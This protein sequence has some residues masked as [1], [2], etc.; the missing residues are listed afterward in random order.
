M[1]VQCAATAQPEEVVIA[2]S[3]DGRLLEGETS[4]IL[5]ILW[6]LQDS[7]AY[8]PGP[9]LRHQRPAGFQG[10]LLRHQLHGNW[11]SRPDTLCSL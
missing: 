11:T 7:A 10:L 9:S 6:M 1:T 2:W 8:S 5:V 3:L 4:Q